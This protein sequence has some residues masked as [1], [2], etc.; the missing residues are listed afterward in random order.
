MDGKF[1]LAETGAS[2]VRQIFSVAAKKSPR[3]RVFLRWNDMCHDDKGP[4]PEETYLSWGEC[5]Q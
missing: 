4:F 2:M 3:L 5:F 1:C